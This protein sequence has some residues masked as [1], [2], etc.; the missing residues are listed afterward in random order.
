MALDRCTRRGC[1]YSIWGRDLT[2][3]VPRP[4]RDIHD[5][6]LRSR[7]DRA[8]ASLRRDQVVHERFERG[9]EALVARR[10]HQL[11]QTLPA[12]QKRAISLCL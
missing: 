11:A 10:L 7:R 5:I 12:A 1:K 8:D 9:L 2:E 3:I 6:S 4:P